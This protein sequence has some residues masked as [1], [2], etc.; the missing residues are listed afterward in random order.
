M[1]DQTSLSR[2]KSKRE[3][4][5]RVAQRRTLKALRSVRLLAKCSNRSSYE[6]TQKEVEKIFGA[7]QDELHRAK[8]GFTRNKE[9]QFSLN[10]EEVVDGVEESEDK[11]A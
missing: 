10:G 11:E 3:R 5:L 6:Y 8:F 4:F 2:N 9:P 1:A 7:L